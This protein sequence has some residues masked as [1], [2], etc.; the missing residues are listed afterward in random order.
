MNPAIKSAVAKFTT[1]QLNGV[2]RF[3]FGSNA[4]AKIMR[5]FPRIFERNRILETAVVIAVSATGSPENGQSLKSIFLK[6]V[7]LQKA[8]VFKKLSQ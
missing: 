6:S 7:I 3:L 4:T 2:R 8:L 5:L 1:S